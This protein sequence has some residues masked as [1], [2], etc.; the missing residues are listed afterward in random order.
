MSVKTVVTDQNN[1]SDSVLEAAAG[2]MG[3]G[4]V[5]LHPT[6]TVYGLAT[7]W[8][9]GN[10]LKR[11]ASIKQHSIDKPLSLLIADTAQ[12]E[13]I[14]GW[15]D[16]KL[17]RLLQAVFPGPVTLLLERKGQLPFAYWNQFSHIGFR[18]PSHPLSRELA[19]RCNGA[20]I[21]TSANLSG[22]PAA[23]DF[24]S[25]SREI[26]S[27]VSLAIDGGPCQHRIASTIVKPDFDKNTFEVI[28][29]GAFPVTK[30]TAIFKSVFQL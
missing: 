7:L 11:L 6:E 24:S 28:R 2:L 9:S 13:K 18:L 19:M 30:M 15:H 4:Q 27:Q 10:G 8:N 14:C 12:I 26:V 29:S 21:T 5:I 3:D 20:I 17:E 25:V 16:D 1:P 23:T 22:K